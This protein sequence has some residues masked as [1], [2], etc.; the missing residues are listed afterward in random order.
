MRQRKTTRLSGDGK[1]GLLPHHK[2]GLSSPPVSHTS[3]R[4]RLWS[5]RRQSVPWL[6]LLVTLLLITIVAFD[7]IW[8]NISLTSYPNHKLL[9]AAVS[10]LVSIEQ[11]KIA[12]VSIHQG[13]KFHGSL[14][15]FLRDS[16]R[17]YAGLHGYAFVDESHPLPDEYTNNLPEWMKVSNRA[18]YYKNL[19]L[20]LYLM[21][22]HSNLD[23]F[24]LIDGDAVITQPYLSI[25]D[26]I[27]DFTALHQSSSD[28]QDHGNPPLSFVWAEDSMP[29]SGVIL[30]RNVPTGREYLKAALNT[31]EDNDFFRSFADQSSLIRAGQLN[32]TFADSALL[33]KKHSSTL[34]QSRVRGPASGR[35][36][37]GH[38]ILHLPNHNYLELLSSLRNVGNQLGTSPPPIFPQ[39]ERPS[40]GSLSKERKD[41]FET[42]QAA[43]RHAWRGY[44]DVCLH[45][46][47]KYFGNHIPYDDLSPV[48][49]RG[50]DW[51]YHAATLYDSL[52]TLLI[53]FGVDSHEYNEALDVI[54]K[55]DLQ[56]TAMRPT[57][58]FEYSLRILGGLLGAFSVTGD[59]R[60]LSRARDAAD[61]LL[62]GPFAS[63]PT[64]LPRMFDVLYPPRGGYALYKIYA[65]LYEWGRD[66]FTNEHHYNSL[67]GVG[68]FSLE[69]YFLSQ[70]LG[71]N[72]YRLA[73]DK[74]FQHVER[75]QGK[76][77]VPSYFNVM[78]GEPTSFNSGLGSGSDS[79]VEY[80]LKVPLLA[81][82]GSDDTLACDNEQPQHM[83][84]L[85]H[86][87]IKTVLTKHT[88]T[89]EGGPTILYPADN[90]RYHQL[91][92]FLPGVLALGCSVNKQMDNEEGRDDFTLA[93]SL[94]RGCHDMYRKSP[95][96]LGPEEITPNQKSDFPLGDKRY[97][98]RPEYVESLFVLY[99][100]TGNQEYQ[101]M[102]WEV[103]QSL[104]RYCKTDLGYAGIKDVY[105]DGIELIDEMPSYFLAET[106]K[107]LMLLFGPD[108]FL[109]L[110]SYV[111]TTEAHP[112]RH[113]QMNGSMKKF[114]Y[115]Q[116][117]LS[118][119]K[120]EVRSPFPWLLAVV[121]AATGIFI[122]LMMVLLKKAVLM[123][124]RREAKE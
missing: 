92:C 76:D 71:T 61:A 2:N 28:H 38:W 111:F 39:L 107:Y 26:R 48:S 88:V 37:P 84:E 10:P 23:W 90:A 89:K 101:E 46:T 52:D 103:F 22:K 30:I 96:G 49:G 77:G 108:D 69:F 66:T 4:Y 91:L 58:T 25:E 123:F 45:S 32:Q 105:S 115:I 11:A 47:Y 109:S 27:E 29:N 31:W 17:S 59:L 16:K 20:G 18:V 100:L 8:V 53:A 57:K 7:R 14:G 6:L 67:A 36:K 116:T 72:E 12:I 83:L 44:A 3:T 74:I 98:L 120:Y 79:F 50:D 80:L 19:V 42:V 55:K 94:V 81:C 64:A 124:A 1:S 68:S 121:L 86:T 119:H 33:L 56:A 78:T 99:R 40:L 63:S 118:N 13:F 43:I 75:Y 5:L 104:E 51:L 117:E 97:L 122:G 87:T 62:H 102:G 41:R 35:W 21:E 73:A 70:M 82:A 113:K 112:M 24:L 85:Y 60:L 110:N 15:Q 106:L 114:Q 95:L 34:L 93:D 9:A 65:R 54:L